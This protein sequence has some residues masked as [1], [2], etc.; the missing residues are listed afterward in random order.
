[1]TIALY[2][3][4]QV[5]IAITRGLRQRGVDVITAEEVGTA[6]FLDPELLDHALTLNR[7]IFTEDVDFLREAARR[8]QTGEAFAGVIYVHQLALSLGKRINDLEIVAKVYDPV[9][10]ANQV[11]YLPL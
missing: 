10:L 7:V 1:V 6:A 9:D 5:P 8:Q 4:H 2:M 11:L 3:D